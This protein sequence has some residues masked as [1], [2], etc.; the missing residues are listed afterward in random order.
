[1]KKEITVKLV[2][3]SKSKQESKPLRVSITYLRRPQQYS[4]GDDDDLRLT[5]QQ[6]NNPKCKKYKIAF[7][8]AQPALDVARRII[9][10][11]KEDFRS[12]TH[13]EELTPVFS[14]FKTR[15]K[16]E[17][18]GRRE[19][20]DKT[21]FSSVVDSYIKFRSLSIKSVRM[22]KT[23]G[24]WVERF[25]KGI[26]IENMTDDFVVEFIDFM[27][28]EH[29]RLYKDELSENSL[30]INLRHLQAVYNFAIE[31]GIVSGVNPFRPTRE[32]PHGSIK[33]EQYALSEE[34]LAAIL[35]YKPQNDIQQFAH[36]FF[37]LTL[38]MSG[39]NIGD[40]LMLKNKNIKN[41]EV[42][43]RREKTKKSGVTV[44]Y[45]LT[46][47]SMEII[48]KYGAINP[49]KPSDYIFP[50]M[51]HNKSENHRANIKHRINERINKGLKEIC[52]EL[53][54]RRITLGVARHTYTTMMV[55]EDIPI[56]V[57]QVNLGHKSYKTTEI[58][59]GGLSRSTMEHATNILEDRFK[60][61]VC[62]K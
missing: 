5:K 2:L 57:L 3:D 29:Y 26:R 11:M 41:D 43:F 40:I 12:V 20:I 33:R 14:E 16:E 25:R 36:D 34:E 49:D 13:K 7:E 15:F 58:Y 55:N 37:C 18:F 10:D 50:Y 4:I 62:S 6:F 17:F 44:K 46:S 51:S 52:S 61:Q 23:S 53:N 60:K 22:Y 19:S 48:N 24:N 30:R 32:Q 8:K 38:N 31:K 9:E 47:Y 54:I 56:P 59:I 35:Q 45:I 1:M 21:L 39:S 27:K 28:D 42:E